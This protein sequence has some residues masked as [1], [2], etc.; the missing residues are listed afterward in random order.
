MMEDVLVTAAD[1]WRAKFQS[2]C[3]HQHLNI[4]TD[5]MPFLSPNQQY[6]SNEENVHAPQT[7]SS[8][9]HLGIFHP[10]LNH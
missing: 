3:H 9:G 4:F 7:C 8:H 1:I 10:C 5:R 6:Q 2:N